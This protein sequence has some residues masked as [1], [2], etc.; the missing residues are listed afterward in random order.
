MRRIFGIGETVLDI[1][2][3]N[4]Q[5]VAAKA[6]GSSLNTLVSLARVDV[7]VNFITEIGRDKVGDNIMLFLIENGLNTEFVCRFDEG[8]SAIALAYLNEQNDA[9]YEF[10]KEYPKQRLQGQIPDFT[11]D[12]I[13][14]FG[15]FFGLNPAVRPRLLEYLQ[16]ARNNGAIIIYDPNFRKHHHQNR[17]QL[18][19]VI[20]ENFRMADFVRGSDEDFMN[21][22]GLTEPDE[23]YAKVA[24]HCSNLIITAG[25]KGVYTYGTKHHQHYKVPIIDPVS[26]IGAG[27]NFNAGIIKAL[28]ECDIYKSD[29]LVLSHS[30]WL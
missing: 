14:I 4:N 27:D 1:I 12:D 6:G 13:V 23:V 25:S 18:I 26:T 7:P 17:E 15:S 16:A 11:A 2:F 5:P 29:E 28:L 9:E 30:D 8:K 22:Y 20:E 21:I 24:A 10:F 3:K 19:P